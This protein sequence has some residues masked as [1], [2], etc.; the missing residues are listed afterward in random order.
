MEEIHQALTSEWTEFVSGAAAKGVVLGGPNAH[1]KVAA[2]VQA[3]QTAL[4]GFE[5]QIS[6]RFGS[7]L[8]G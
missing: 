8:I 6:H 3:V 4:A 2:V 7:P 5:T 1:P